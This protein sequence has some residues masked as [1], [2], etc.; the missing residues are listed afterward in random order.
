MICMDV[1]VENVRYLESMTPRDCEIGLDI[2]LR[3]HDG[4]DAHRGTTNDVR[5]AGRFLMKQLPE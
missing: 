1:S 5:S 2:S 4:G 3:I